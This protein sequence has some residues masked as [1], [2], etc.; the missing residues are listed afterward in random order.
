MPDARAIAARDLP[1]AEPELLTSILDVSGCH[2][3]EIA[4]GR[5]EHDE[6]GLRL[7]TWPAVVR[8][9]VEQE[10][11]GWRQRHPERELRAV[12]TAATAGN[13]IL[14]IHHGLRK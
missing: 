13:F 10:L 9:R 3:L 7:E 6:G 1:H 14:V 8:Q 12:T 11:A 5:L 4:I 2:R